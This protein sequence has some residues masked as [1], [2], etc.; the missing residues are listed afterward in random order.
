M[1]I[2]FPSRRLQGILLLALGIQ[3]TGSALASEEL[4]FGELPVVQSVS[5]LPQAL[6]DAPGSV[7]VIDRDMIRASGARNLN[8][9]FR[10][11]PGFQTYVFNTDAP[12]RVTYHGVSDED[13]SPRVQVLVDGRSQ[14]SP[15]FRGGVNWSVVPVALEDIERIEVVRG[16]N[17]A[18]YGSNAFLGVINII[19]VDPALAQGLSLTASHGNQAVRDYSLRGGGKL[20]EAGHFRFTY[21]Q[22]DDDGLTDQ[23]DW[24]DYFE[25]RMF[26]ARATLQLSDRDTLDLFA[27]HAE[28]NYLAGRYLKGK[29]IP[30]TNRQVILPEQ[31]PCN[32][33]YN[34]WQA[35]S[36]LQAL[37]QR[38]LSSG[39]HLQIRYAHTRDQ[40]SGNHVERCTN[41]RYQGSNQ[42]LYQVDLLGDRST[43]DELELQHTFAPQEETRLVWGLGT[44][45][46]R[47]RSA[48]YFHGDPTIRRQVY[49]AFANL[50]W[51][52][53]EQL[54]L[55]LGATGEKDS[56]SQSTFA[57]RF[58]LNFHLTPENTLRLGWS[59]AYR[60]PSMVDLRGDRWK[61]PFATANGTPI[62]EDLVYVRHFHADPGRL[63]PE[64]ITSVELGYLGEW[65]RYRMSLD[66]RLY[67]E[68]IPNRILILER[69]HP[70]LCS[71]P[72]DTDPPCV[73]PSRTEYATNAQRIDMEGLEY[74]W[75]WQ[76]LDDTR[77]LVNQAFHHIHPRYDD[78]LD[79]TARWYSS[80]GNPGTL[81]RIDEHTRKSAPT[82]ATTIMLMQKLPYGVEF[83]ATQH[84]VGAMKWTRNTQV[85]P[86]QRLD[87]RLAYPFRLGSSRGMLAYTVQNAFWNHGEFKA[88][89]EDPADRVVSERHWLSLRLDY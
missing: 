59:R 6:A 47:V 11:V 62:P 4:F 70:D 19:T 64:Q 71:R 32:P 44:V 63:E 26:D 38:A 33:F 73:T 54:T 69:S 17:S 58:N 7:T 34:N 2:P 5:R 22:Q 31:D 30:G 83:S 77:L 72:R 49:R 60:A 15:L 85:R 74:Q 9:L 37:W 55:N 16:S 28:G 68:R 86:Y 18:A 50:E 80:S 79:T 43:E 39:S 27:G 24:R 66:V 35:S 45:Q 14:Y 10:L 89:G 20:G 75:R 48:T 46:Q 13:F 78:E 56:L 21:Q 25:G 36:F 88:S 23:Y 3:H 57:P 82:R 42:L 12:P 53:S 52:P 65:K 76:P 61:S 84:W 81:Y 87:L 8:D 67:R 41:T 40:A 29:K 51:R 1:R